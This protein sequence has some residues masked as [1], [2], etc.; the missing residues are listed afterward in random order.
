MDQ[1]EV[2]ELTPE[3]IR[4]L[5]EKATHIEN[6]YLLKLILERRKSGCGYVYRW[7]SDINVLCGDV[8]IVK[9]SRNDFDECT[10]EEEIL[11]VPRSTP[12]IVIKAYRSDEPRDQNY[13]DVFIFDRDGWRSV[14]A[15]VPK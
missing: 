6:K 8:D 15:E 14:R 7:W 9:L 2:K 12:T 10:W 5:I 1:L 13:I 3:E 4:K 11:I